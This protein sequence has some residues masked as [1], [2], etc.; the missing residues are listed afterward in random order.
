MRLYL[1]KYLLA[2]LR[3]NEGKITNTVANKSLINI[4]LNI[5]SGVSGPEA[6][7]TIKIPIIPKI[8]E[9]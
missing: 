2:I 5:E 3:A 7:I 8:M 4:S 9:E 1:F 6:V